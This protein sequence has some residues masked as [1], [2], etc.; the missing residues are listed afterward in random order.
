MGRAMRLGWIGGLGAVALVL[1]SCGVAQGTPTAK[2]QSSQ[3]PSAAT[4]PTATPTPTATA[5]PEGTLASCVGAASASSAA[6]TTGPIIAVQIATAS[7]ELIDTRGDVLNQAAIQPY[8]GATPVGQGPDGIYLYTA[9]TGEVALL[10][11]TGPLQEVA[12]ITAVNDFD[13]FSLAASPNGQ[14]WMFSDTSYDSNLN[15]TSRMYVGFNSGAAPILLATLTRSTSTDGGSP[16]YR[17]LRWDSAGVLLGSD[18][19]GVG[20]G[21]P[22]IGEGYSLPGVV[23]MN[24]LTG[25]LS[26]PLCTTGRFADVASDGT[27]ACLTGWGTDSEIE[28]TSPGGSTTTIDTGMPFAGQIGFAGGSSLLTFCTSSDVWTD[29]AWTTNLLA[30]QLGAGTPMPET[31]SSGAGPGQNESSYAW[32]KIVD[33]TSMFETRGGTGA[34]SLVMI[35]L[36][37]G[38]MTDIVAADSILGVL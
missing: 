23:R 7:V 16:G 17:L 8:A 13:D 31:L 6:S 22:F 26:P 15:G 20:G 32:F 12:S 25:A 3:T 4:T 37:T 10:G 28:V 19:T 24:P 30:V 29:G 33:G 1:V 34:S 27:L 18:P 35:N 14:C 2:V 9:S 36:L 11:P 38:Q 5:A 21:G